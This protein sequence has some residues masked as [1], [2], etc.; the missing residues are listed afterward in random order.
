M[1]VAR[2]F[3]H[4]ASMSSFSGPRKS[5]GTA[6]GCVLDDSGCEVSDFVMLHGNGV[7]DPNRVSEMVNEPKRSCF[8]LVSKVTGVA[9]TGG[10]TTERPPSL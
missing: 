1:G 3:D 10:P 6:G 7:T 5:L 2:F 4:T 9:G 8:Y